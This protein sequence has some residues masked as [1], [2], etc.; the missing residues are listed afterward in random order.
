MMLG[1]LLAAAL[2][3]ADLWFFADFDSTPQ[4]AGCAFGDLLP[5]AEPVAGRYGNG[6][7]FESDDK[8]CENK[9][10]VVRDPELLKDFP[11]E[12]GS[13]AC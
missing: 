7:L 5:K 13:F 9:Y 6:Y 11:V 4:I 1:F 10:W 12:R 2:A 8:R 3:P